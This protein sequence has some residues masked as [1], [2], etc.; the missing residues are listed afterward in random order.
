ML[1]PVFRHFVV[2]SVLFLAIIVLLIYNEL[3]FKSNKKTRRSELKHNTVQ[4]I[5]GD[6]N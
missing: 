3:Y 2:S 6:L 5:K 4:P 1:V